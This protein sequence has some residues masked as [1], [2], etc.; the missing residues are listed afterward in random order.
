MW[1]KCSSWKRDLNILVDHQLN[2]RQQDEE[3]AK[4]ANAT[5][6]ALQHPDQGSNNPWKSSSLT[7]GTTKF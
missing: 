3:T 4:G 7:L 5:L 6:T 1:L 2:T